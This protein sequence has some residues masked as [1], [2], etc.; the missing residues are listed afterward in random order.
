[1]S[2]GF[3]VAGSV[4]KRSIVACCLLASIAA[5]AASG[6][7]YA[8]AWPL[9]TQG[10]SAA[11]QVELT[12]EV[13]AAVTR[14]DL[15][16]IEVVNA[17]GEAV[18]VAPRGAPATVVASEAQV[19]LP[20]FPLPEPAAAQNS[21]DDE[22]IRLHVERGADGRLR[23]LDAQ[24]RGNPAPAQPQARP[25]YQRDLILDASAQRDALSSLQILWD[26]AGESIAAQFAVSASDDLQRW[27]SVVASASVLHLE[28]GG[29]VLERHG[30][31]LDDTHAAYLRLRRLDD[32]PPL[33][34]LR[35]FGRLRA[36]ANSEFAGVQW[37]AATPDGGDARYL[38]RAFAPADGKHTVA[39]RYHL[40]AP[41]AVDAIR[42]SLADDNSLARIVA[43]SRE[44]E[45][46]DDPASWLQRGA[47]VAFRLRQDGSVVDNDD[48]PVMPANRASEWRIESATPLEHAP[49]LSIAY[50]PD[51]LVFLAQGGGPYRLV[52]GS[53]RAQR[54][55][56]PLDTA[57][58][59]LRAKL[60]KDW[61]PPLAALGAR[62]TLQGESALK[63]VPPAA[64]TQD[65]RTWL[66]WAVLVGAAALIGGLAL[67]LLRKPS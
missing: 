32:G 48:F 45:A 31:A 62:A 27:R 56:Y 61:Q 38:S 52:A 25:A 17:A 12:P 63:P 42:I 8:Y 30:V 5:N 11:W 9:Q 59:P 20:I 14:A 51:R 19:A 43:I 55:D 44:R 6:D 49:T 3:A 50:R 36:H 33:R 47:Y 39:Y 23:S 10:D 37:L 40:P 57:L 13:Y 60:G 35:V 26:S 4:V 58:A 16:D 21:G 67:S 66:L 54:G 18:P 7:D 64:P 34:D 22:F 1:M 41:L 24:T 46:Y 15:R 53:A 28:Q 65:W 2:T 29:N